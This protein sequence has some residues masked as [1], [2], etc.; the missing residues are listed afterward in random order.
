MIK[1]RKKEARINSKTTVMKPSEET[2][3]SKT[4]RTNKIKSKK[5]KKQC[6]FLR[7][8][9]ILSL[10][11]EESAKFTTIET[12][13]NNNQ[14]LQSLFLSKKPHHP[15]DL[16][17]VTIGVVAHKED[18]ARNAREISFVISEHNNMRTKDAER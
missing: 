12:T 13:L 11:T 18:D 7:C 4:I 15:S 2:T 10:S 6:T 16:G 17:D 14:Q 5:P 8:L 3:G 9:R 1:I